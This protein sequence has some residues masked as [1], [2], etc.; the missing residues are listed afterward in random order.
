MKKRILLSLVF[1]CL[2]F[3]LARSQTAPTA[4]GQVVVRLDPALDELVSVDAKLEVVRNGLGVTEGPIWVQQG[5]TGY[6]IFT[7]I[8]ANV[9]YK[10]TADGKF[11]VIADRAGYAG[12]DPWNAGWDNTNGRDEKD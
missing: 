8:A 5:K 11:S 3:S 9:I 7:D 10:M 4:E 12:Y 2:G 1:C 6:L